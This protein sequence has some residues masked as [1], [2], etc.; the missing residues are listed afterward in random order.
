MVSALEKSILMNYLEAIVVLFNE[1][2]GRFE[3]IGKSPKLFFIF[4]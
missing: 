2:M 4:K 3:S 1:L